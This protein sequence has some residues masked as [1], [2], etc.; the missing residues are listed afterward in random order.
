MEID[1]IGK[2][3]D[4][5]RVDEKL[6]EGGM[7]VVYKAWDMDLERAVALKMISPS[8]SHDERFMK[9]FR[10]EARALAQLENSHIVS[11][12]DLK[13]TEYGLLIVMQYVDGVTLADM[14]QP[15]KSI[16]YQDA[17]PIIKQILVAVSH[18][19]RIGV[20]HRDLKPKNV[21]ITRQGVVKVTDF[22][23][24]KI[25]GGTSSTVT[26]FAGRTLDY[27]SPEHAQ[28][29]A[30]ADHRI[31]IYSLGM[32]LYELLAGKTPFKPDGSEVEILNAILTRKFPSPYQCDPRVPKELSKIVMKAIE[33]DPSHRFQTTNQMLTAIKKFEA[34]H[35]TAA[36]PH[37]STVSWSRFR[38]F[39]ASPVVVT[40]LGG[41]GV[42]VASLLFEYRSGYFA[43]KNEDNLKS[44]TDDK[45]IAQIGL[46]ERIRALASISDTKLFMAKLNE[47]RRSEELAIGTR[48]D[49]EPL[50]NCYVFVVDEK[51]LWGVFKFEENWFYDVNSTA[52]YS[53]LT[54]S[55]AGKTA[56][57]VKDHE[58]K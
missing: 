51:Q 22:G 56:I 54:E 50:D 24:A 57:W 27:M 29:S 47:Y 4:K 36:H 23:L 46:P 32:M 43:K 19:H 55:F 39:I 44:P 38:D 34:T 41:M 53:S 45:T 35:K 9:R 21:M 48:R 26:M 15:N 10:S 33:K 14:L 49:F 12:H 52:K 6:G 16:P 18:A 3:I 58:N 30:T 25:R 40:V 8:F 31:D 7:G 5:Y 11:I 1:L 13:E 42:A 2:V 37:P 20:V 17:L 28:K